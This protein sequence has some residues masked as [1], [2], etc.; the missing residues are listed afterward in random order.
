MTHRLP[1]GRCSGPSV[2]LTA[3]FR[4][5]A[6]GCRGGST[7]AQRVLFASLSVVIAGAAAGCTGSPGSAGHSH[8][9]TAASS[10]PVFVSNTVPDAPVGRQLT[11]FLRTVADL[12]LSQQIIRAHF[13]PG[14][15]RQVRPDELNSLLEQNLTYDGA[16]TSSGASLA[17][18]L[19]QDPAH[20]PVSLAAVAAFG[21]VKLTVNISVDGAGRISELL[22]RPYLSSWAQIDRELAALAPDAS[23]LTA[24]VSPGGRCT[25]VHQMA[26]STPRPLASMFKLFVLGARSRTRSPPGESPGPRN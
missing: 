7:V 14:V 10:S 9:T 12:P 2:T 15:L 22:L 5:A 13:D 26:A 19:W 21:G 1:G 4:R 24:R 17:G 3:A 20:H 8:A 23:L 18:L 25:A 6:A 16:R 11:W